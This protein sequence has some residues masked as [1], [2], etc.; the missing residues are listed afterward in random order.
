MPQKRYTS[1]FYCPQ[2]NE[3]TDQGVRYVIARK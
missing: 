3:R 1:T 2:S